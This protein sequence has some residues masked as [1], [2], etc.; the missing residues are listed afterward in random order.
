MGWAA[1]SDWRKV[2]GCACDGGCPRG[3]GM[4]VEDEESPWEVPAGLGGS[5]RGRELE[6][7][8]QR[9]TASAAAARGE[10]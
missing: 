3:R 9:A 1:R 6:G 4:D 5:G 2:R 7:M 10:A 8:W